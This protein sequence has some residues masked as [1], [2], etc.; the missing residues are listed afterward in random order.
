MKLFL[1]LIGLFFFYTLTTVQERHDII[2]AFIGPMDD[3]VVS[4]GLISDKTLHSVG[5][6]MGICKDFY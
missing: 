1:F 6:S 5:A 3:I 2:K 4:T